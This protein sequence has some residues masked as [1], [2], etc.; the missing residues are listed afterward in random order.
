MKKYIVYF[1]IF[2]K[3]MKTEVFAMNEEQ[4][5]IAVKNKIIFHK[6]NSEAEESFDQAVKSIMDYL[7]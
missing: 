7:K 1:E 5:M 2:G 4:A 3:K 6:V